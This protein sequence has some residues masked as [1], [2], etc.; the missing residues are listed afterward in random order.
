[1]VFFPTNHGVTNPT[2][3]HKKEKKEKK[4]KVETNF[5]KK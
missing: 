4:K 2:H 1:M 5:K 3:P